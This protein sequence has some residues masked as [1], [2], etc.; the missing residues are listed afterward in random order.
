[1]RIF[2]DKINEIVADT[3]RTTDECILALI[4]LGCTALDLELGIVSRIENTR[5]TVEHSNNRELLG[6]EF[7]LGNTYCAITLS[8]KQE[9]VLAVK[10]FAV[11]EFFRHPAY[12]A[13][14]LESYIGAPVYVDGQ[15]Y[16]TINFTKAEPRTQ[17]FSDADHQLVKQLSDAVGNVLAD[18]QKTI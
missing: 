3:E 6:Q 12:S 14:K 8:L 11:S 7:R 13:F 4:D 15:R 18:A 10:H 1:M 9:R 17:A 16:G 5:Y 2:A